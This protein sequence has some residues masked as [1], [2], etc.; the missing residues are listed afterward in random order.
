VISRI[1]QKLGTAG[2]VISIVALVAALGGG[3]YAAKS[4]LTGKQK[5]EV[6]KIA[7]KFAGAPG[8]QGAKGATGAAGTNGANGE[9][10]AKGDKGDRGVKGEEGEIPNI[11]QLEPGSDP[12]CPRGG[13]EIFNATGTGYACNGSGGGGRGE[14]GYPDFLPEGKTE[15][16]FY[17]ILGEYGV[18]LG[19]FRYS[20][21]SFPLQLKS[22]PELVYFNTSGPSEEEEEKCPGEGV[23][24]PGVLCIYPSTSTPTAFVSK[25]ANTFGAAFIQENTE[26]HPAE[27]GVGTWA[28]MA[29]E[30]P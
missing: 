29:P 12:K 28:V 24:T 11:V 5:K 26:E 21:I 15:M 8:A 22:A 27:Q 3:A 2:F 4:G 30:E 10:G 14:E 25:F 20:T 19:S 17:E 1:H 23:A 18:A 7:R 6:E 16:G 13:T 9:N